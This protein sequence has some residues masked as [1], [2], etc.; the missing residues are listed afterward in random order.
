MIEKSVISV[1]TL[2]LIERVVTR[3]LLKTRTQIMIEQNIQED[4]GDTLYEADPC[5]PFSFKTDAA[6][7][8]EWRITFGNCNKKSK[9]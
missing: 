8:R 6:F 3:I 5:K 7:L 2:I 4:Y 9:I 1:K